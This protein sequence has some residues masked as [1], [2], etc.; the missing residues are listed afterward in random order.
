MYLY[1]CKGS[2]R[3]GVG[4][5][6][7]KTQIGKKNIDCWFPVLAVSLLSRNTNITR[8]YCMRITVRVAL[9]LW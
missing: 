5:D 9:G 1:Y 8:N 4:V 3:V 6:V 2:F 7:N